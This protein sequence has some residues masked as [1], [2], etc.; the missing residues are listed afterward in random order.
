MK[1]KLWLS[2]D[3]TGDYGLTP[4]K[5]KFS[6]GEVLFMGDNRGLIINNL[7]ADLVEKW[8]GLNKPLKEGEYVRGNFNVSFTPIKKKK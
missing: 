1:R 6:G 3:S 4:F 7:C 5:P 8:F 2:R